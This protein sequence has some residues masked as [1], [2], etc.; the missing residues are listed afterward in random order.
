MLK[1]VT[2]SSILF[3]YT[4]H[5]L[6]LY[7]HVFYTA[8]NYLSKYYER[9]AQQQSQITEGKKKVRTLI[10]SFDL[11]HARLIKTCKKWFFGNH[12]KFVWTVERPS[13]RY[14]I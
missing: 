5:S 1:I 12:A 14:H 6:L 10:K 2:R 13:P 11:C 7:F 4:S 3:L 8:D 9:K